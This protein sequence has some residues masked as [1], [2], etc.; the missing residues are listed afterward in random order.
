MLVALLKRPPLFGGA[1]KSFD[2]SAALAVPGVAKVV[3]VPGG[4]AV[5]AKGFWAAKLGRDALVVTGMIP[6]PRSAVQRP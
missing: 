6:T 3:Q 5:I 4:V 2:D 1:V